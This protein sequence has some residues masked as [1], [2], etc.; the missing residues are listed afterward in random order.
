MRMAGLGDH[1]R[2]ARA[3]LTEQQNIIGAEGKI[4]GRLR[5]LCGEQHQ[6]LRRYRSLER[7]ETGMARDRDMIDIIHRG[8]PHAAIIPRK[9]HRLDKI[10]R[11]AHTRTQA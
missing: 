10:D 2:H 11:R 6:P 5:T 1:G 8:A 4:I 3:F 9:A 7:V